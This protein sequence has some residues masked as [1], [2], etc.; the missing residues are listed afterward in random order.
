MAEKV[1]SVSE[2]PAEKVENETEE[3]DPSVHTLAPITIL[4]NYEKP[5]NGGTKTEMDDFVR[6]KFK[7]QQ[8]GEFSSVITNGSTT[9]L[10][11]E[12]V[13]D[14]ESGYNPFVHRKLDHPMSNIDTLIHLLKGSLGSGILAMPLAFANAGLFFGVFATIL[15]GAICT[16]CVHMLVTCAHTLYRRMKVPTLDYSGVA[17]A[18]FLLGP[19]PVRKY[20]RL[21]KACI[22]TFLFIDLYGC[23]CVYV[24]FVARNLKQVVD[25]H[26]EI[27]YDVRL[28]MAMLLI[29]L[30]LTNLIH[31]LKWLAPFSMIA[32]ILMAVGIGI[33]F[34]Y[35]FNDLPHVTERKYFSSFQQLPLFFGT[36]I[37]ALEGIGVVMPLENNMK[38]PQK[39][40]G[41]PG[42]LNI[43]MTVV[44]ILYTAVGFFGYL[45]FGEDTQASITLNLPKDELLAQSVKVMIAVTIFLTYSLQFYVPMGI[46]W[47]GCK[48]W[49]PKNEVPAEYCIRIFLVILSVGIA[50]AVP[51]LGPFISLVGA[52]CLSTLG[53]IFPA[54]IELVTFWEKPG[55]GKF[56]WRIWKNIFLMLF[57]ILGFATGTI[58]S[59][60]EI[61]ETFNSE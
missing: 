22:D 5:K 13:V 19:Q 25:H 47:K 21:A 44:V 31:N 40:I 27:D 6:A 3:E 24:V 32:N 38:T 17:E 28:Y 61:M 18:S 58:S 30:I 8:H 52:M 14:E 48:H 12:N 1:E 42:V 7:S 46:I 29:P 43:G 10:V 39:F 37:F 2:N 33:S 34:Y 49:F 55:M 53:L 16:Y 15:V 45:K 56:Y 50:A 51:N 60:Q 57:G 59:L 23:C 11:R 9:P 4:A 41:C 20:R 36:A 35:V 26:L 54:V